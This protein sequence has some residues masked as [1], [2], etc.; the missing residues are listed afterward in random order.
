MTATPT[1]TPIDANWERV[2]VN[3]P[4]GLPLP[5]TTFSRVSVTAP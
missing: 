3:Q 1:I 2:V 5:T 4:L